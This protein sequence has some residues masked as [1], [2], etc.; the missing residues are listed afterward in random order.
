[1]TK[2]YDIPERHGGATAKAPR[3]DAAFVAAHTDLVQPPLTPEI[4]L[5]LAADARG[6]FERADTFVDSGLGARPYWAFAWPGGQGL[7]RYILD[8]PAIVR[9]KRILDVGSGSAIAAIAAKLAGA[10]SALAADI[11]PIACAAARMNAAA[12]SVTLDVTARDLLGE[13]LDCDLVII[14]DLVYEPDLKTRVAAFID[15]AIAANVPVLYGDRTSARRPPQKFEL[16]AE[17]EAP[18]TPPLVDDFI[19]RA[20]VWR[21]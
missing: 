16:L 6:I 15:T 8:N 12:N 14:G 4:R 17:Y 2:L 13:A 20:R 18:L 3:D 11:D 1:M 19:E 10:A 7:A 9:G 5:Q 21:L